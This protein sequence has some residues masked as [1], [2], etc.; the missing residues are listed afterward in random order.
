MSDT[1][2]MVD[3]FLDIVSSGKVDAFMKSLSMPNFPIKAINGKVWWN[4]LAECNG[5]KLQKN[6]FTQTCRILDPN[7]VRR[8]WGGDNAMMD[9][10]NRFKKD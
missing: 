2:E 9:L 10:F 3:A 7:N 4:E 1:K 8:A 5:W 6:T